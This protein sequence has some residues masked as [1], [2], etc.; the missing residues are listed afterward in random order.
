MLGLKGI[1]TPDTYGLLRT[2]C[3]HNPKT[4]EIRPNRAIFSCFVGLKVMFF[5]ASM[6]HMTF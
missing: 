5:H 4:F 2:L 1:L 6:K 3:F